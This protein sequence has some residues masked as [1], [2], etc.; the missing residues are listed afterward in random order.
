MELKIKYD[1]GDETP[2]GTVHSWEIKRDRP[3]AEIETR[4]WLVGGSSF[5]SEE[6]IEMSPITS[7]KWRELVDFVE[8][9]GGSMGWETRDRLWRIVNRLNF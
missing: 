8:E 3:N 6:E 4:Y 7:D 9:H 1:S 2:L 5:Y